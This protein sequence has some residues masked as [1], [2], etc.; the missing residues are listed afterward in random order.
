MR[1]IA[2]TPNTANFDLYVKVVKECSLLRKIFDM[3]NR[4]VSMSSSGDVL[5]SIFFLC[6]LEQ[7][8][9]DLS[10]LLHLNTS[11]KVLFFNRR[12]VSFKSFKKGY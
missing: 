11:T 1:V 8:K 6:H 4:L 5:T 9:C 12:T 7:E 3:G 2:N 10:L